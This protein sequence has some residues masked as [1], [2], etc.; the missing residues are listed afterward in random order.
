MLLPHLGSHQMRWSLEQGGLLDVAGVSGAG[1]LVVL[2]LAAHNHLAHLAAATCLG[3]PVL[4]VLA[5]QDLW[6]WR[7]RLQD[8]WPH[9]ESHQM[10]RLHLWPLI[11]GLPEMWL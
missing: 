7:L 10:R 4:R 5:D 6:P 3:G 11:P 1:R 9:L 2:A 8:L